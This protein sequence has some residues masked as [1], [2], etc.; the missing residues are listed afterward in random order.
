MRAT[1]LWLAAA[2]QLVFVTSPV[3]I[4]WAAIERAERWCSE[5]E[6]CAEL[7]PAAVTELTNE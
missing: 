4:D 5:P 6:C 2:A 7:A 1:A 3:E